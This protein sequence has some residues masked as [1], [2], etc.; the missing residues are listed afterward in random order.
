MKPWRDVN[1]ELPNN[2]EDAYNTE[3]IG[4]VSPYGDVYYGRPEFVH[5]DGENWYD[6]DNR[7]CTVTHWIPLNFE[8]I[9]YL[10]KQRRR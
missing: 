7:T 6:R 5:S 9:V 4:L 2:S 10:Y 1:E 3:V 8:H